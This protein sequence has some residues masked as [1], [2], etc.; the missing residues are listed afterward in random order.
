MTEALAG[1]D[2]AISALRPPA[3]QEGSLVE[4]TR[5]LMDAGH[6]AGVHLVLVGGAAT[7]RFPDGSGETVLSRA[8]FLPEAVVP[9]AR[10]CAAQREAVLNHGFRGFSH[11]C[12]PALL[13]PGVRTGRYR[14]GSETLVVDAE[15]ASRISMEDF[16]VAL[17]DEAE[18]RAHEG[19]SFTV[20]S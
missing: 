4:L 15:G 12:P 16:A 14:R 2:V 5:S 17:V 8:G 9:I 3:G 6:A 19:R 11:V 10:A 13:A 20:G 1:H 18:S 7:L